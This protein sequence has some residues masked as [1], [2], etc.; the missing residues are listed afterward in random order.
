MSINRKEKRAGTMFICLIG[1]ILVCIGLVFGWLMLRSYLN[2]KETREWPQTEGVIVRS[3]LSERQIMG[4]P[5]EFRFEILFE[6]SH[7]GSTYT[8]DRLTPRGGK[9][10][11]DRDTV[12]NLVTMYPV[13]SSHNAWVNPDSP[14][15]AILKHDTKAAGYTLWFPAVITIGGCGIIWGALRSKVID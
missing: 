7:G 12:A 6:Y 1:F 5:A 10:F 11:R 13:G 2:A 14:D 8:S 15:I 9:W 3:V 4:S